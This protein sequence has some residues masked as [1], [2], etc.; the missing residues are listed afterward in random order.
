[1][2]QV[3]KVAIC[4]PESVVLRRRLL[5]LSLGHIYALMVYDSPYISGEK[6][7]L[8]DLAFAV[9]ICARSFEDIISWL[10][11]KTLLRDCKQWGQSCRKL[12]FAA[13]EVEFESYLNSHCIVPDRWKSEKSDPVLHPWPLIIAVSLFPL[14]GESRAW[15]MPLP[16]AMS[17]WSAQE[18]IN[19]DKS[20]K[21]EHDDKLRKLQKQYIEK[22]GVK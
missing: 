14:V 13:E 4:Q 16:L 6:K 18:E 20:L 21:S 17:Y 7:T 1:M 11:S 22:M 15:N 2:Q 10:S 19:G 8:I 5:P 9:G 3:F 12:N